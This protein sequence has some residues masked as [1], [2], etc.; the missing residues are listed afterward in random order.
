VNL[1]WQRNGKTKCE[2]DISSVSVRGETLEID[3]RDR[4]KSVE[5]EIA[6]VDNVTKVSV[7]DYFGQ[8]VSKI[9]GSDVTKIEQD[10]F[11]VLC[12]AAQQIS[13]R[14]VLEL[15]NDRTADINGYIVSA[16]D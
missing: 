12:S 1:I 14:C 11:T 15:E 8:E 13:N 6:S 16:E 10:V 4:T 2:R 9:G 7:A 5:G 3:L